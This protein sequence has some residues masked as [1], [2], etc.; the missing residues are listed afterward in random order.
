MLRPCAHRTSEEAGFANAALPEDARG[1]VLPLVR[2]KHPRELLS[3]L[4]A[5]GG[6]LRPCGSGR[7]VGVNAG[8]FGVWQRK[9][10]HC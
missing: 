2:A 1:M 4:D 7:Y 6:V 5:P 8:G 9:A 10:A 3:C